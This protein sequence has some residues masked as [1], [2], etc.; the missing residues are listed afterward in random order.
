M[1]NWIKWRKGL[2]NRDK[3]HRIA[4]RMQISPLEAAARFMLVC[5]WTDEQT[6]D[7]YIEDVGLECIDAI[8]G[9][10]GFGQALVDVHWVQLD[11]KGV[12]FVNFL[13]H[14]GHSAK[15]RALD[16]DRKHRSREAVR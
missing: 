9:M 14:N 2:V 13:R 5:E 3:I 16:A 11:P 6:A 1:S 8:A 10:S 4:R 12:L 15:A 7:G